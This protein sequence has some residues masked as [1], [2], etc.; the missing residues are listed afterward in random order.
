MKKVMMVVIAVLVTGTLWAE[1]KT[2]NFD[3]DKLG[4]E[5]TVEGDAVISADQKHSGAKS[6]KIVPGCIVSC[7]FSEENTFGKITMWVYDTGTSPSRKDLNK[8]NKFGFGNLWGAINEDEDKL[9]FGQIWAPFLNGDAIYNWSSSASGS[10]YRWANRWGTSLRRKEGWHKWVLD[11]VSESELNVSMDDDVVGNGFSFETSKFDKG[12][13]GLY[14]EG[15][16]SYGSA[17]LE[18]PVYIDDIEV[19]L[20][21]NSK[22]KK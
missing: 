4:K 12:I 8:H 17:V 9:V 10:G 13:T 6:L 2:Y 16:K 15:G 3:S 7:V 1:K 18:D 11:F 19:E 20:K 5:W 21:M 14:F 22:N